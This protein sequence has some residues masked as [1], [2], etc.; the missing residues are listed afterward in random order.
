M[1]VFPEIFLVGLNQHLDWA[2]RYYERAIALLPNAYQAYQGRADA[3][4]VNDRPGLAIEDYSRAIRLAPR[5]AELYINRGRAYQALGAFA[6]TAQDYRLAAEL[7]KK[8]HLRRQAQAYLAQLD[9][10]AVIPPAASAAGG[11]PV[12]GEPAALSEEGE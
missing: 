10:N 2:L 8:A 12:P 7:A 3:L 9:G 5:Q 1:L 11:P 6:Q 4:R